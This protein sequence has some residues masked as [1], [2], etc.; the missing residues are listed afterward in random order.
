MVEGSEPGAT[1]NPTTVQ[2]T[3]L[4]VIVKR[5]FDAPARIVFEAW[6]RPELFKRWWVPKSIGLKLL[7]L[8]QDVRVGGGYRLVFDLGDSRT[9]AFFGKYVE[10]TPPSRLA[11]TNEESEDGAIST[12]T[13]EEKDGRTHLTFTEA[14]ATREALDRNFGA[15]D[16]MPE[17]FGQLDALLATLG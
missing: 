5:T 2:R 9:L 1:R 16:S 17:Q 10:V 3:D 15:S 12:V 6:T 13:F 8:E 4:A 7:S 11:W 14:Y